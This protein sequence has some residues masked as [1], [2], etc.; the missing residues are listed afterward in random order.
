MMLAYCDLYVLYRGLLAALARRGIVGA[1]Y[2]EREIEDWAKTDD[3]R[4]VVLDGVRLFRA[5]VEQLR[6]KVR[7]SDQSSSA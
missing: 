7:E 2:L 3:A 1:E 6:R 4:P 5:R